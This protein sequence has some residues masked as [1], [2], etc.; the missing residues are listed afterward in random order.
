MHHLAPIWQENSAS[1]SKLPPEAERGQK[2][3]THNKDGKQSQTCDEHRLARLT[4]T[5]QSSVPCTVEPRARALVGPE[6]CGPCRCRSLMPGCTPLL[7]AGRRR[8]FRYRWQSQVN[9]DSPKLC[10]TRLFE[11]LIFST[12]LFHQNRYFMTLQ[13]FPKL[14]RNVSEFWCDFWLARYIVS[15]HRIRFGSRWFL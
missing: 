3:H 12:P 1:D 14:F 13:Y 5:T 2:G 10:F 7:R 8:R 9:L 6:P 11:L 4:S 15:S